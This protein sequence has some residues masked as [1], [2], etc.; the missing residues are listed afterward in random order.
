MAPHAFLFRSFCDLLVQ[1]L[2]HPA[3]FAGILERPVIAQHSRFLRIEQ[4]SE[5]GK[6]VSQVM[7]AP[8]RGLLLTIEPSVQMPLTRE[9]I[10]AWCRWRCYGGTVAPL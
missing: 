8:I 1:T 2:E 7:H 10:D 4:N 3:E 5:A 6:R 9:N